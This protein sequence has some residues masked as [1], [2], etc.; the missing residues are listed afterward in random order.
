V[1]PPL[2]LAEPVEPPQVQVLTEFVEPAL[3]R[4]E[5]QKLLEAAVEGY[6]SLTE[7]PA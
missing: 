1:E 3:G 7:P 4:T 6:Y 5:S 2:V